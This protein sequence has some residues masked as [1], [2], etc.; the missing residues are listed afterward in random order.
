[1]PGLGGDEDATRFDPS[2]Q[3]VRDLVQAILLRVSAV[4]EGMEAED[5]K[6]DLDAILQK[7]ARRS[8]DARSAAGRLRYWEKKAPFG[9]TAP[10][11]MYS[12]EEGAAAGNLAWPTPNTMREVE[13]ST[14]FVLKVIPR[15]TGGA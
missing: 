1:V 8:Q 13:P 6:A 11:L 10:H 15:K 9:R 5:T 12:A 7:W 4:S 3:A 2:S 14:A